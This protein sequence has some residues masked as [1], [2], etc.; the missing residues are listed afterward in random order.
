MVVGKETGNARTMS[1]TIRLARF[2]VG[3]LLAML[4]FAVAHAHA[5]DNTF[6]DVILAGSVILMGTKI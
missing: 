3:G 5:P 6:N 2:V 4:S 1:K